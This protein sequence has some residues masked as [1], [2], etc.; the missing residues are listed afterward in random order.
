MYDAYVL[1]LEKDSERLFAF[2]KQASR[3][4][5]HIERWSAA[6]GKDV[7]RETARKQGVCSFITKSAN[8]E[9]NKASSKI[10]NKPGIVGCW[11]SHKSLLEHLSAIDAPASAG[12]AVFED[13]A[14]IVADFSTKWSTFIKEVPE[15]WDILYF[16]VGDEESVQITPSVKKANYTKPISNTGTY[17]YVVRHGAIPRILDGLKYMYSPIDVQFSRIFKNMHVYISSTPLVS[18]GNFESSIVGQ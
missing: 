12:H 10:L 7:E 6:Y 16:S 14:E 8:M 3:V 15:D 13:D 18:T 2:N 9:D 5:V 4:P 1:N 17:G 11:L